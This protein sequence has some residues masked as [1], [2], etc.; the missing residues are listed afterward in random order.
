MCVA[1]RRHQYEE[2]SGIQKDINEVKHEN[3]VY[4][5]WEPNCKIISARQDCGGFRNGN[6]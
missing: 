2:S 3:D 6:H 5:H 1:I 4:I